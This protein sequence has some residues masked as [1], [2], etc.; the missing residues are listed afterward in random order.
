ML[1]RIGGKLVLDPFAGTG[2]TMIGADKANRTCYM[3]EIDPRY[4]QVIINRWEAY[5]GEKATAN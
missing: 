3:M 1:K 4:C 5:T 2:T